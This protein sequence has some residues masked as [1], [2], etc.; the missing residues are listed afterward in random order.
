MQIRKAALAEFEHAC[1][2]YGRPLPDG[3]V[4]LSIDA[5][6]QQVLLFLDL[7]SHQQS[8]YPQLLAQPVLCWP[9]THRRVLVGPAISLS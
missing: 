3:A 1:C 8:D 4:I 7:A 9:A 2:L 5:A 6:L